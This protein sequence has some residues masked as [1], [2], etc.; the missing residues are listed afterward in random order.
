MPEMPVST[1]Q[2]ISTHHPLCLAHP[3]EG[4]PQRQSFQ[5]Q[6]FT[7]ESGGLPRNL[8]LT[9]Q[10]PT[11][12]ENTGS[13]Y[14]KKLGM[15]RLMNSLGGGS[16]DRSSRAHLLYRDILLAL[17]KKCYLCIHTCPP[18]PLLPSASSKSSTQERVYTHVPPVD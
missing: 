13:L 17:V 9:P 5:Q 16:Q 14:M 10:A 3:S 18:G 11:E 4:P 1:S 12:C 6:P 8:H 2:S 15:G 7:E